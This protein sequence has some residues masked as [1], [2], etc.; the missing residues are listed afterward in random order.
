MTAALANSFSLEI[1]YRGRRTLFTV[2]VA[3]YDM[4][5]NNPFARVAEFWDDVVEDME[6]TAEEYH[7]QGWDTLE[8]HPGDVAA[9]TPD[10]DTNR[11]GLDLVVPGDEFEQVQQL[12]ESEGATFESYQVFKATRS[13]IVFLVVAM[14]DADREQ[15]LLYPAYYEPEDAN[16][17][18]QTAMDEEKLYVHIRKLSEDAIITFTHED[19][20]GFLPERDAES[21]DEES[22]SEESA[23]ETDDQSSAE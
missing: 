9:L 15:A 10:E 5:A 14:E 16:E 20:Q 12:L 18:L 7:E 3:E 1:A 13:G 6:V 8:L 17:L 4:S 22:V 23:D 11:Y 2:P 21:A 19:P